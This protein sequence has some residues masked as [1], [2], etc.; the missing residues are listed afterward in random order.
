MLCATRI[1]LLSFASF[2]RVYIDRSASSIR[3]RTGI[4]SYTDV[5]WANSWRKSTDGQVDVIADIVT[6]TL[7]PSN[8]LYRP[9]RGIT[10][11]VRPHVAQ[12]RVTHNKL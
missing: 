8:F 11:R 5:T 12:L 7:I 2:G 6:G 9:W 4:S 1:H 3:D 10:R